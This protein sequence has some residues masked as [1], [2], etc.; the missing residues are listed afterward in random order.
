MGT[1]S[2]TLIVVQDDLDDLE[3]VN[4]VRYVQWM[5]DIAKEHWLAKAPEALIKETVWVVLTHHIT[6]KSAAKLNDEIILNTFIEKS[7]G[8]ICIRVVEM[9]N[10]ETGQLLIKAKTEWCL[11]KS[12]TFKPMRISP[13]IAEIFISNP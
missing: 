3:H 5:Q 7:K 6:Y 8:P 2:K 11:L 9:F 12:D 10:K 1:F 4:N 13:E